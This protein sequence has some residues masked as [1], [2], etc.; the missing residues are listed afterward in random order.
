MLMFFVNIQSNMFQSYFAVGFQLRPPGYEGQ[1]EGQVEIG[2]DKSVPQ[3]SGFTVSS[4][5]FSTGKP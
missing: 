5:F 2:I 1:A 4:L 3:F